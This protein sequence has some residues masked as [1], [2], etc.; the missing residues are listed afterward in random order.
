MNCL[1][2]CGQERLAYGAECAGFDKRCAADD[3][4]WPRWHSANLYAGRRKLP[5]STAGIGLFKAN[6]GDDGQALVWMR[7]GSARLR[8]RIAEVADK[9]HRRRRT[10]A[11]RDLT[12]WPRRRALR[13]SHE[14][15]RQDIVD[16]TAK[17]QRPTAANIADE[18]VTHASGR[19]GP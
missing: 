19:T 1:E 11:L 14:E 3:A 18:R 9:E 6:P 4:T 15:R 7:C 8:R 17:D 10:R 16:D 5:A 13:T 2:G 12:R